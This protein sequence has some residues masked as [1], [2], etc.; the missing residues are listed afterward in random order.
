[1]KVPFA[2]ISH[3]RSRGRVRSAPGTPDATTVRPLSMTRPRTAVALVAPLLLVLATLCAQASLA[4]ATVPPGG[5]PVDEGLPCDNFPTNGVPDC[6][7]GGLPPQ[8]SGIPC[9]DPNLPCDLS[10][11]GGGGGGGG[12]GSQ[13]TTCK[14]VLDRVSVLAGVIAQAVLDPSTCPTGVVEQG[15]YTTAMARAGCDHDEA[16]FRYGDV[17]KFFR[18]QG[19]TEPHYGQCYR[20]GYLEFSGYLRLTSGSDVP[21]VD[22]DYVRP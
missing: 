18:A 11:G 3:R 14:G 10:N 19:A 21:N 20:G 22:K 1:M 15:R 7:G 4:T 17:M 16:R 13:N 5:V 8:G 9:Y 6:S 2:R 12:G